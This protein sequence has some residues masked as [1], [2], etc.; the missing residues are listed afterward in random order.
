MYAFSALGGGVAKAT[1]GTSG[2]V[3]E[4][5]VST[6]HRPNAPIDKLVTAY[7]INAPEA[8]GEDLFVVVPSASGNRSHVVAWA[9]K[10]PLPR[11]GDECLVAYD[12]TGN[13]WVV[14]WGSD[15]PVQR[16]LLVSALP[17][18][19]SDS[20]EVFFQ[21]ALMGE[22]GIVWHLRYRASSASA[23]KWEFVGGAAL[24]AYSNNHAKAVAAE[25]WEAI[26]GPSVNAPLA[27]DYEIRHDVTMENSSA[28]SPVNMSGI[29]IAGAAPSEESQGTANPVD[30]TSGRSRVAVAYRQTGVSASQS[31]AQR[32][33]ANV[34][35]TLTI[36]RAHLLIVPIRL[37]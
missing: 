2:T 11:A 6:S 9:P 28:V 32:Y 4:M 27:G 15:L 37:G 26:S 30:L 21:N 25:T 33:W 35:E 36:S 1:T 8:L 10:T 24:Y 20:E 29:A 23:H 14:A 18:A 13:P 34:A 31:L 17:T 7:A 16:P 19:P 3:S 22:A 5:P 12:E